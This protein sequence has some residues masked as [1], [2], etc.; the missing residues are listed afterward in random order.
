MQKTSQTYSIRTYS[1]GS[2]IS[3]EGDLYLPHVPRPPVVCLLHGGFWQMPYG[4]EEFTA[5]AK[6]LAAR[7]YA[8]WN[9]EYRRLGAAGGGWPGTL[10]D[11]ASAIDHL[12]TLVADGIGLDL[13]RVIVAGHS[14]GG[15]LALWAAARNKPAN[16]QSLVCVQPIAAVGLAAITDLARAFEL[17]VGKGSVNEFLGGSPTQYPDRYATASPIELLPI[18]VGQLIIHG[19]ND[20]ELPIDLSRSYAAAAQASGDHVEFVELSDE[21]HMDFLDPNSK[22]HSALCEW[23]ADQI[24]TT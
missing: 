5:V 4:R 13:N 21:G 8:V 2:L 6:D 22:G 10:H 16:I 19:V 12:A 14:A 9:I 18:G 3:Q 7:G 11:A 17:N 1:Y 24:L 15:H 23:L 20:E